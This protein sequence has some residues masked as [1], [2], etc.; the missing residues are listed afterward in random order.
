MSLADGIV[1]AQMDQVTP[2]SAGTVDRHDTTE[3][4]ESTDP[5][6][7]AVVGVFPVHGAGA[8]RETV[9]R[10]R[11]AAARWRAL[12]YDGRKQRLAAHRGYLARRMHELADLVHREN[13][14]PHA[15]AILEITLAIDH[16]AWAGGHARKVLGSR[17]VN[18]GLLAVGNAVV[19]KPRVHSPTIV[20]GWP[21]RGG[22]PSPTP[23]TP[24]RW[25]PG[26]ARPARRCAKPASTSW[27][28]PAPRRPAARSGPPAW[29][30]SSPCSW[31][32]AARTR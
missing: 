22:P 14:K 31:S 11:P 17:R 7:G 20:R 19:F 5:A 15:D 10:A 4:F 1:A 18:P 29:R 21:P 2:A 30:T 24:S 25:S 23:P 32:S 16:L 27:P 9:E 28:S 6:T 8:V 13:G 3:T 12:G 26:S